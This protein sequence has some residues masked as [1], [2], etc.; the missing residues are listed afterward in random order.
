MNLQY[1]I[2]NKVFRINCTTGKDVELALVELLCLYQKAEESDEPDIIV[3]ITDEEEIVSDFLNPSIHAEIKDGFSILNNASGKI[4][5]QRK[6]GCPLIITFTPTKDF[7]NNSLSYRFFNNGEFSSI[8]DRLSSVFFELILCPSTLFF[9][10]IAMIHSASFVYGARS[11]S[12]GGTGGIGK[13]SL[14]I[15]LCYKEDA[16]F[17][18]DDI[19]F[20]DKNGF[21]YPNYA[22][23]KI[24]GYNLTGNKALKDD[25]FKDRGIWD[26]LAWFYKIKRNSIAKV[27][28]RIDPK[29]FNA[30]KT[31]KIKLDYYFLLSRH[32]DEVLEKQ[33]LN[34]KQAVEQTS[35]IIRTEYDLFFKHIIWHN[36]NCELLGKKPIIDINKI[37]EQNRRVLFSG[38][39]SVFIQSI[40]IPS[41]ISHKS[42]I[43]QMKKIVSR[44]K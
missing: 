2:I 28:R 38:L 7:T 30:K 40:L 41:T 26:K 32:N 25:I 19:A 17:I 27:R 43:S 11:I 12:I 34:T 20:I 39:G 14:E 21:I 35:N 24:Y 6:S 31:D 4:S 33:E 16:Q 13:T 3:N 37:E 1:R 23:P 10:D 42:Y 8:K 44:L 9:D 18:N 36:Y 15:D 22:R 5:F 29:V